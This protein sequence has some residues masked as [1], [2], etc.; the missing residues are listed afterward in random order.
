MQLIISFVF[1]NNF[2]LLINRLYLKRWY[3]FY[4][5]NKYFFLPINEIISE[6]KD[7]QDLDTYQSPYQTCDLLH[8]TQG[9]SLELNL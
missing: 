8:Q 2:F 4:Y 6:Y 1:L 7:T 9:M 3:L 5:F